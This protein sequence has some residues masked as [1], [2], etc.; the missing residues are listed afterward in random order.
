MMSESLDREKSPIRFDSQETRVEIESIHERDEGWNSNEP[1]PR[2]SFNQAS[3]N[4]H[5]PVRGTF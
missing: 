1:F 3:D 5:N 4:A 2:F